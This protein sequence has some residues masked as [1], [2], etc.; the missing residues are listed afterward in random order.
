MQF[1]HTLIYKLSQNI[2]LIC[3]LIWI[4]FFKQVMQRICINV[5]LSSSGVSMRQCVSSSH[6]NRLHGSFPFLSIHNNI[7]IYFIYAHCSSNKTYPSHPRSTPP[8][9]TF[10]TSDSTRR[11]SSFIRMNVNINAHIKFFF[12]VL[13]DKNEFIYV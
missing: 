12:F 10:Q 6:T 7:I 5:N 4:F 1:I 13:N 3:L 8:M 9:F 2:S 11:R